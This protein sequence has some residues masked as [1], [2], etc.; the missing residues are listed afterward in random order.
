MLNGEKG[1]KQMKIR[2]VHLLNHTE[3][4]P[5]LGLFRHHLSIFRRQYAKF[6]LKTLGEIAGRT[7]TR[8][9]GNFIHGELSFLKQGS[10]TTKADAA[11]KCHRSSIS[12]SRQLFIESR[13]LHAEVLCQ[14]LHAI[15]AIFQMLLYQSTHL[16]CSES[17]LSRYVFR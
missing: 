6:L 7:E 16:H 17:N 14:L 3:K 12:Q 1:I 2:V 13:P 5:F 15:F 9:L 8:S 10:C 11:D 4:A